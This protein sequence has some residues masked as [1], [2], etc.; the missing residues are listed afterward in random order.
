[1]SFLESATRVNPFRHKLTFALRVGGYADHFYRGTSYPIIA[2]AL[3]INEQNVSKLCRSKNYKLYHS[4]F[5]EVDRLGLEPAWNKYVRDTGLKKRIDDVAWQ[6]KVG[7]NAPGETYL[8]SGPGR[9]W[10]KDSDGYK[11]EIT[12]MPYG[13]IKDQITVDV[14]EEFRCGIWY[15][16]AQIGWT[17]E[18]RPFLTYEEALRYFADFPPRSN[19]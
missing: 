12:L 1:M 4:V 5:L 8:A 10:I 9:Y 18:D 14:S 16:D 17:F 13:D 2:K 19:K 11:V 7:S 6:L 3:G 15:K